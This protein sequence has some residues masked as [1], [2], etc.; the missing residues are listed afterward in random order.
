MVTPAT[1]RALVVIFAPVS[2]AA[3]VAARALEIT[4]QR[5]SQYCV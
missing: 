5:I 1:V 2:V 3:S 4:R